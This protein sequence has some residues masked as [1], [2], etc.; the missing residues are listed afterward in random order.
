MDIFVFFGIKN[1]LFKFFIQY[2]K[3][4]YELIWGKLLRYDNWKLNAYCG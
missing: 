1:K 2:E 3:G 4:V